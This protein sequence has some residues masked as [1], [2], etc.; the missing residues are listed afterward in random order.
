MRLALVAMTLL[1][2][3]LAA[4]PAVTAAAASPYAGPWTIH[5]TTTTLGSSSCG[6]DTVGEERQGKV[7]IGD[8]GT[9]SSPG[10][11]TG[12][13]VF[14]SID[15]S[16]SLTINLTPNAEGC[17]AS[18]GTGTCATINHCE[19]TASADDGGAFSFRLERGAGGDP[20]GKVLVTTD[21]TVS[22]QAGGSQGVRLSD[23]ASLR[24]GAG[25][26]G[27]TVHI[28]GTVASDPY[29]L[30]DSRPGIRG[31]AL[32]RRYFQFESKVASGELQSVAIT[33]NLR[34][35]GLPEDAEH[36][37]VRFHYW[38]GTR[39]VVLDTASIAGQG[40]PDLVVLDRHVD[41]A[42]GRATL[43]V[44]HLSSYAIT[45][46]SLEPADASEAPAPSAAV[47]L[48][49]LAALAFL[50]RGWNGRR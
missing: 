24:V 23:E 22:A 35:L 45:L 50:L 32:G 17:P 33:M 36:A 15:A 2:A 34:A 13:G 30:P 10:E 41:V 48:V 9:F 11:P 49:G 21:H 42:N 47:A 39:W 12:Y 25:P 40:E 31:E 4:L 27:V 7:L 1:G 6:P 18:S 14:L 3:T 44:N 8:D 46:Q 37:E 26:G 5:A 16:G 29:S 20:G 28:T 19:G 43:T 38:S